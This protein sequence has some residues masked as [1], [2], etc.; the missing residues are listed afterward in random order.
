MREFNDASTLAIAFKLAI[1]IVFST[2]CIFEGSLL[3]G[4]ARTVGGEIGLG[5]TC[6]GWEVD[7]SLVWFGAGTLLP[8]EVVPTLTW[9]RAIGTVGGGM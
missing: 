5:S 4:G 2:D 6:G 9:G 7:G 8:L 3:G 1:I